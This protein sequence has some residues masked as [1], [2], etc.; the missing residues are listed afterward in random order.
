M[1]FQLIL[2][3]DH[4]SESLKMSGWVCL[5]SVNIW[6]DF[7]VSQLGM[8]QIFLGRVNFTRSNN[9]VREVMG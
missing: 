4:N 5:G 6:V 7:F 1:I 9:A 2:S 3:I 8:D